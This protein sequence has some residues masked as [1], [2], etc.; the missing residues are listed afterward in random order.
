MIQVLMG[1]E[2]AAPAGHESQLAY[3]SPVF[4]AGGIPIRHRY[5][6][7]RITR[8]QQR[9]RRLPKSLDLRC[10]RQSK[11]Y[12][13]HQDGTASLQLYEDGTWYCYGACKAGGS[14]SVRGTV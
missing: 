10:G 1:C 13:L 12:G 2:R 8:P 4:A 11:T 9:D 3:G 14:G 7:S 5:S 6:I